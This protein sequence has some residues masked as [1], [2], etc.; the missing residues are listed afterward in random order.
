MTAGNSGGGKGG[1]GNRGGGKGGGVNFGKTGGWPA[2]TGNPCGGNRYN[3]PP[4]DNNPSK[5][6]KPPRRA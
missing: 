1:G 6:N 5:D 2:K 4:K 3:N